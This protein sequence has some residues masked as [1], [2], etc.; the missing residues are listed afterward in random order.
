MTST[1]QAGTLEQALDDLERHAD[2]ALRALTAAAKEAKRLKTAAAHGQLRDVQQSV[3][4]V[5]DLTAS[6][7]E[8]A[9]DLRSS[10]QFDVTSYFESDGYTKEL[11]AATADAGVQAVES[12]QRI[13]AYPSIVQISPSDATVVID[14]KKERR[15]RPSVLARHL[16]D[17]QGRPPK[18]KPEAFLGTLARAYDLVTPRPGATV[19]LAQ[20]Y[21]VLTLL[22]G[23]T[24]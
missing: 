16:A 17:L 8:V 4:A 7:A 9:A 1:A 23:E 13:L 15:V 12:D 24:R 22:P 5:D 10:W 20:V 3:E 18:F 19:K 14:K 6:A 21:S 2:G 11:L